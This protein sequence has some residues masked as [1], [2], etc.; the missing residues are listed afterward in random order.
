MTILL[1]IKN[2]KLK[3]TMHKKYTIYIFIYHN[4]NDISNDK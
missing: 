3:V 4:Y 1:L 2:K